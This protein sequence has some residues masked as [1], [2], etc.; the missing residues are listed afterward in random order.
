MYTTNSVLVVHSPSCSGG[1]RLEVRAAAVDETREHVRPVVPLVP[2]DLRNRVDFH[3]HHL[4]HGAAL[5]Q[6]DG[7]ADSACTS[8]ALFAP[9]DI[10]RD[11]WVAR[12]DVCAWDYVCALNGEPG[13][14]CQHKCGGVRRKSTYCLWA[15]PEG[16]KASSTRS[17]DWRT[18]EGMRLS[19]SAWKPAHASS[20]ACCD[21]KRRMSLTMFSSGYSAPL[22]SGCCFVAATCAL[23]CWQIALCDGQ[24]LFWHSCD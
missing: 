13:G 20:V 12:R 7:R 24:C 5:Y 3:R 4:A 16:R 1:D 22:V 19:R 18:L 11:E 17:A 2:G 23:V 10:S 15:S 6:C 21:V 9:L 14:R 8:A